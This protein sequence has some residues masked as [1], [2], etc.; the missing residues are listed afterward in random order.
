MANRRLFRD[1]HVLAIQAAIGWCLG[2]L[3]SVL[4]LGARDLDVPRYQLSWLGSAFGF[5]LLGAGLLGRRILEHG[6]E[7][8]TR[9]GAVLVSAGVVCLGV[10]TSAPVLIAG[11]LL[12]GAG[13]SAF[14]IATPALI[15]VDDRTRRL[16]IAV[17]AS[18]IAGL[19]APAAVALVDQGPASGR[20]ALVVPV[21][22]LIPIA[23][24]RLRADDG[25]GID[26]IPV[27][28]GGSTRRLSSA[29]WQRWLLIVLAVSAEFFFWTW[30]TAR[31]VDGGAADDAASGL[32]AAFAVGMALGRIIGPR[33]L[34]K[35]GPVQLSVIGTSCGAA[36]VMLDASIPILVGALFLAGLGIA[37]MY[38][39]ALAQLLDDPNLP[40]KRLIALAAY[41]S[42]VAIIVTPTLLGILDQVIALRYAFGL[43][44]V[45]MAGVAW[46]H[47]LTSRAGDPSAPQRPQATR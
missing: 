46:L 37:I 18:S 43:V 35:L 31:L 10:G 21:V 6:T 36:I 20:V 41:A 4:V 19:I 15:G 27:A 11:G 12:Q 42:G 39:V 28:P 5:G 13:C 2:G 38:P 3:G 25:I 40:E 47:H 34:R 17:G 32:A 22:W 30:G 44:P 29:T 14:L 16:A 24:R 23:L 9:I 26:R 7:P 1:K 45:L 33:S 8:V